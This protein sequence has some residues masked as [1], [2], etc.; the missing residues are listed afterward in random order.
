MPYEPHSFQALNVIDRL[1]VMKEVQSNEKII[2]DRYCL[3]GII[4]GEFEG[5]PIEWLCDINSFLPKPDLIF[6]ITGT[7]FVIEGEL[8]DDKYIEINNLYRKYVISKEHN[9]RVIEIDG[10]DSIDEIVEEMLFWIWLN[11]P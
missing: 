9:P 7:P 3:S 6:V 11:E 10:N 4:N 2:F 5:L 1:L 8:F